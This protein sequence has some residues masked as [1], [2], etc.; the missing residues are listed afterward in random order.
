MRAYSE[1]NEFEDQLSRN[2]TVVLKFW[3]QISKSEQLKRFNL[4]ERTRFK[5][6]KI[7]GEDWRNREK[8]SE[9]QTAAS[10]M[11]ERT[12]AANA[13]WTLVESNDKYFARIKVLRTIVTAL[14]RCLGAP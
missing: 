4:R 13:P 11:I 1:I 12:N 10:D 9:Y 8:W 2:G 3:M 6:F 14:D 5:Q 7:T